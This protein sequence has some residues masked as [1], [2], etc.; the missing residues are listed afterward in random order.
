MTPALLRAEGLTA[1]YGK[2]PI[3]H[4]LTLEVRVGEM[5]SVIGPNGASK[6]SAFKTIVGFVYATS[7]TA[8]GS[9]RVSSAS[10]RSSRS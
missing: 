3:L 9:G 4:D 6:S 8:P 1:G 5:V 2:L 10:T 7:G